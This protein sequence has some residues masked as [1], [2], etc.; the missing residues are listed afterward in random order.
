MI[1]RS[2][3]PSTRP[4]PHPAWPGTLQGCFDHTKKG[5]VHTRNNNNLLSKAPFPLERLPWAKPKPDVTRLGCSQELSWN[6]VHFLCASPGHPPTHHH[7]FSLERPRAAQKMAEQI[8]D[9]STREFLFQHKA[10][11]CWLYEIPAGCI[12]D[13]LGSYQK[14]QSHIKVEYLWK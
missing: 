5:F 3:T 14:W 7:Q 8:S 1:W 4:G 11:T 12:L 13:L 2:G 9:L 6:F 10:K